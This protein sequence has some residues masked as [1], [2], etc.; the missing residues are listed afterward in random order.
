MND[1]GTFTITENSVV[2]DL[3]QVTLGPSDDSLWVKVQQVSPAEPWPFSYG[4]LYFESADG[5]TLGTVKAYGHQS[6]EIFR[7]G[8]GRAPLLGDGRLY[9]ESRHYNLG[10][11]KAKDPPTWRL[12]FQWESGQSA[13][14]PDS[15]GAGATLGSPADFADTGVSYAIADGF[16]RIRLSLN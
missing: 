7:I 16:A 3:G 1:L 6:G 8:T 5:R 13:S 14:S 12:A 15:S 9:W 4:L 11:V 2:V 10:W